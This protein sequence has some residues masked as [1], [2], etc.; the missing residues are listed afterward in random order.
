[1]FLILSTT[2]WKGMKND[3]APSFWIPSPVHEI[4]KVCFKLKVLLYRPLF[5]MYN[6]THY[7]IK[8]GSPSTKSMW[9][10]TAQPSSVLCGGG[11]ETQCWTVCML[12]V[13][14]F[15]YEEHYLLERNTMYLYC[16]VLYNETCLSSPPTVPEKV[17][18][19]SKWSTYTNVSQNNFHTCILFPANYLLMH[20]EI[21]Q[22]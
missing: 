2:V 11:S 9:R 21:A 5:I 15:C 22:H 19:I 10:L 1:V 6:G 12:I 16:A 20:I 7:K 3:L 17:V 14:I 18:N 8:I 4:N 13:Y